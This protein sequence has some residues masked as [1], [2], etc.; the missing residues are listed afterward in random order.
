M[1]DEEIADKYVIDSGNNDCTIE[2]FLAGLKAG[3]PKWHKVADGD[4]P[5]EE[6]YLVLGYFS[7]IDGTPWN[8]NYVACMYGNGNWYDDCMTYI[9][10]DR[11]PIAWCEIPKYTEE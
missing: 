9:E 2:A 1:T 6:F 5:P 4:Y 3:R 7:I 8:S 11:E 10:Q